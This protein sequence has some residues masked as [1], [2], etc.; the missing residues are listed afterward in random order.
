MLSDIYVLDL[1]PKVKGKTDDEI[2]DAL[3]L[4]RVHFNAVK[5]RRRSCAFKVALELVKMFGTLRVAYDG[6]VFILQ[7][8][9]SMS[10]DDPPPTNGTKMP[11][12]EDEE[13]EL[14]WTEQGLDA[15]QQSGEF[16]RKLSNL[17][18]HVA[19]ARG[20]EC[21]QP[22]LIETYREGH[23]AYRS[24]GRFLVRGRIEHPEA[25]SE[26]RRRAM[27]VGDGVDVAA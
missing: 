3:G 4:T 8:D 17:G 16:A 14:G 15:A 1:A 24:L 21:S 27:G 12:P 22:Y 18:A 5:N 13:P 19:I 26:G 9:G 25:E 6:Q 7:A 11:V 2:A 10:P 23:E 20:T